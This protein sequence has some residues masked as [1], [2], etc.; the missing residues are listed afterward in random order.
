MFG[1]GVYRP[2]P[3][4]GITAIADLPPP[5]IVPA[6]RT[7]TRQACPRCG[8]QAYRDKQ[9]QRT[10]HDL[11][12]LDLWCPRDLVVTYSQ[13]YCTQ[14]RTYFHADLS[15]LA[16]PGSQYTHRVIALAVRL[17]VEDGLPY[18]PASWH[19][20]RDHRVF[21]PFATIQNWVEAGGKKAP[22]RMDTDFLDWALADFSGY[23]AADEVYDGPFCILSAVDNR[24]YKR[25]LYDVLDHDPDHDDIRA[26]LRRLK[27][28]L[29][30]RDL[31]LLG[32]TTDGSALY[33]APLAEVFGDVPHQICTF[34]I[35]AE[36]GKA[37]L[38]AVASA[39]KSLAATQ[40][41]LRRGRPSTPVVKQAARTKKR[42]EAQRAA[43]FT[44]RY[45]FVQ[46]HVSKTERKLLWRITRGLPHVH[47]L[48]VLMDQVYALFARRCRTQTALDKLAT[49]RRRLLRF[50]QVG[51]TLKKLFSPTLEKALTFLDDKLLP[52]T[53]N[54]VERGNRRYRKRQKSV[55]RVRTQAQ[56]RARLA[57]DMWREAHAEGRQQTLAAL[58]RA[59]AG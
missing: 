44:H 56:I 20:W 50:P 55:Y 51:A 38:G 12:N 26:F 11:G 23:V 27:T 40:P 31:T 43:L 52:A 25:I 21:V 41:K 24:R 39:R 1:P 37:V 46:R 48:R 30:T 53:S 49:L 59:R 17:V 9:Y 42:L 14:C 45:L 10:L 16:P 2:D 7:Y 35:M 29:T 36:V 8:Y 15:D 19:L 58:H 32:V 28:A 3:T 6:S 13:H 47:R 18:R 34:H 22:A 33:P 5:E 4:E 54:A 57:L